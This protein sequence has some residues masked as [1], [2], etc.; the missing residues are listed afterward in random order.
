MHVW[1]PSLRAGSGADVFVERLADGLRDAGV[2]VTVDWFDARYEF[3][4]QAL[5]RAAKRPAGADLVHANAGYA[6]AFRRFG[7]PLVVTEHHYVLDP[8]YRP[9]KSFAQA[10]YHRAWL[11]HFLHASYR[12]ADVLTTDSEFTARA[13]VAAMPSLKPKVIGL[14]ADYERFSPGE[15]TPRDANAPFRL[16][17][18]G[19]DSRRKGADL[20]APLAQS[21]G[22]AFE[23][24]CTA[25]LRGLDDASSVRNVRRLGRLSPE[26]LVQAY[27]DCDALL[28]PSRYEGFGYSA[29][30]AMACA[31]PVV[32]FACGAV[33]EV[34]ANGHSGV[35]VPVDDLPALTAAI[36]ALASDSP[37]CA[38]LAAAGRL[39]AVDVFSEDQGVQA[40][41][42][43]Y[44]AL[45]SSRAG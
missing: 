17:F 34:V 3:F 44:Q 20:L 6:F 40:Y 2:D 37:R 15:R 41:I 38:V 39:R 12:A 19:N 30:E 24:V 4:P 36:Q 28:F 11:G 5:A 26:A 25:G 32:G 7:L 14:W 23:I 33:D 8:N 31:R 22:D 27:R 1:I 16:L 35:L 43:L 13:L 9:Y 10:V 18:V 42:G 45:L 29:L 21:L